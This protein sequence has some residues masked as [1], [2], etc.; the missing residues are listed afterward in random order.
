MFSKEDL[1]SIVAEIGKVE[2]TT[3]GEIRVSIRQRRKWS[4]KK[5]SIEE[6]ARREFHNLGMTKTKDRTG[7]LIYLML[8][9]KK[10]YILAD[11]GIHTKVD[12]NTW[13]SIANAMSSHFSRK[14]FREGIIHGVQEV[15]KVL[16][17]HVPRRL[18]DAN[19]LPDTIH[20]Q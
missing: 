10:F 1:S 17:Q 14:N 7:V 18:D 6:M 3:A 19:E 9:D 8:E 16:T 13:P 15:G 12:E 4:E 2:K 5:K 11:E 20:I